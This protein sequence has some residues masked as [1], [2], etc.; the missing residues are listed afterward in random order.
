MQ[1]RT[2]QLS[3]VIYNAADQTFEA[4]VSV[5]KDGSSR[6]YACSIQAPI[7][8]TFAE[9]AKGLSTQ[10]IRRDTKRGGMYSELILRAAKQRA[11]RP[12]FDPRRWLDSIMG[13]HGNR[14][15]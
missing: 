13:L 6:K 7:S 9:A 14:A 8:M 10:A 3:D 11:G 15:A 12:H 1:T 2:V 4:L 5:C